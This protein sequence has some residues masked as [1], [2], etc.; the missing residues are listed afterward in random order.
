MT[1]FIYILSLIVHSGSMITLGYVWCWRNQTVM[2]DARW[3]GMGQY[4]RER[5]QEDDPFAWPTRK[6][7]SLRYR[8]GGR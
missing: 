8:R 7:D 1:W 6:L 4:D 3:M 5:I 2:D